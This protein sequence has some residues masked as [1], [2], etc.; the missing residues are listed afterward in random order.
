L[1]WAAVVLDLVLPKLR[2]DA[3]LLAALGGDHIY[4]AQSTR[5]VRV[6]SVEW[7]VLRNQIAEVFAPVELQLDYWA[8]SPGSA[9]EIEE[10]LLALVHSDRRVRVGDLETSA[11]FEEGRTLEAGQPG[12]I[13]RALRFRFDPVRSYPAPA[14]PSPEPP[15]DDP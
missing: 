5:P 7:L 1:T 3:L 4:S 8:R 2:D 13:H 11:L 15:A 9:A 6:P 12:V 10:R 14:P